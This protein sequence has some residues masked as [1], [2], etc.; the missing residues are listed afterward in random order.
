MNYTSLT[1]FRFRFPAF[2]RSKVRR[3]YRV[4]IPAADLRCYS[5]YCAE[6]FLRLVTSG[7]LGGRLAGAPAKFSEGARRSLVGTPAEV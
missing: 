3:D 5:L 6:I 4:L 1:P 7:N 2:V